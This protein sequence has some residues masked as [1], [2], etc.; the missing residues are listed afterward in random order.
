MSLVTGIITAR[1][2][3]VEGRGQIALLV[4]VSSLVARVALGGGLP[5]AVAQL[6]ARDGLSARTALRPF[7]GRWLMQGVVFSV[8]SGVYVEWVL[9]GRPP[10]SGSDSR[11]ASRGSRSSS[12]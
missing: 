10:G 11:P 1:L 4:A 6:I 12:W 8:V 7:V 9:R 5:V 3:G 2:L